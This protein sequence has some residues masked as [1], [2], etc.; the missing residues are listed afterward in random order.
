MKEVT[1]SHQVLFR[2]LRSAMIPL[3]HTQTPCHN[4]KVLTEASGPRLRRGYERM[5]ESAPSRLRG[6][7]VGRGSRLESCIF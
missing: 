2:I 1:W 3:T 5:L 6:S 7:L 4:V